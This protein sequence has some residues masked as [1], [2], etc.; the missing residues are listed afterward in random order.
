MSQRYVT[1]NSQLDV[2]S[3]RDPSASPERLIVTEGT[4]IAKHGDTEVNRIAAIGPEETLTALG[5]IPG[6]QLV[7]KF[8][9]EPKAHT[10]RRE[11]GLHSLHSLN[12]AIRE[13]IVPV[14]AMGHFEDDDSR[15]AKEPSFKAFE[16]MP[17][18]GK[19]LQAF[20]DKKLGYFGAKKGL[21]AMLPAA[22]ALLSI[23]SYREPGSSYPTELAHR[24]IKPSNLFVLDSSEEPN[25]KLASSDSQQSSWAPVVRIGDFGFLYVHTHSD[26][27]TST[28]Y[29]GQSD[30][31]TP[32]EAY[33]L[34][35]YEDDMTIGAK[36]APAVADPQGRDTWSFAATL[37][38]AMTA[39]HPWQEIEGIRRKPPIG[40]NWAKF[41]A[42]HEEPDSTAFYLLDVR[43][44]D[45]IRK[46]LR[47]HGS[48]YPLEELVKVME[49]VIT[50]PQAP[51]PPEEP[52]V[53]QSVGVG[54]SGFETSSGLPAPAPPE[55]ADGSVPSPASYPRPAQASAR[56]QQKGPGTGAA[57]LLALGL[58]LGLLFIPL[59]VPKAS[60][61]VSET[62]SATPQAS[63]EVTPAAVTT[64]TPAPIPEGYMDLGDNIA[65]KWG[66]NPEGCLENDRGCVNIDVISVDPRGCPLGADVLVTSLT[67]DKV[68]IF[69]VAVVHTP[70]L[71]PSV[72]ATVYVGRAKALPAGSTKAYF[73]GVQA[74]CRPAKG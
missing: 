23:H 1:L 32:P 49:D 5:G 66:P 56:K 19:D 34:L 68:S 9:V 64:P 38:F 36:A 71:H 21:D 4:S 55:P 35:S 25:Y 12:E 47:P 43:L 37:F 59:A 69:D 10:P 44:A 2:V 33:D 11:A 16:I 65:Y 63:P 17:Y 46:C 18:A 58:L 60:P 20:L 14:I 39:E 26:S 62:S 28:S 73:H 24:D 40:F 48:R 70:A 52:S 13:G 6:E 27:V 53:L 22:R 67:D 3:P 72:P 50:N 7:I 30:F 57:L 42:T 45:A 8:W 74:S 61:Q 29:F 31:W 54:D 51:S 41:I 15:K